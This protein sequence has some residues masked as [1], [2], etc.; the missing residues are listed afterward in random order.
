[1]VG[2]LGQILGMSQILCTKK[3]ELLHGWLFL[4]DTSVLCPGEHPCLAFPSLCKISEKELCV[5][6]ARLRAT[7]YESL[8]VKDL[9]DQNSLCMSMFSCAKDIL[10]N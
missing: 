8:T 2:V 5:N 4:R 6:R 1:M 7:D 3:V 10:R 9:K